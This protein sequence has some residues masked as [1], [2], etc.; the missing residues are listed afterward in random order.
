MTHFDTASVGAQGWLMQLG[1][2]SDNPVASIAGLKTLEILRRIGQYERLPDNGRRM[3]QRLKESLS[4]A[5]VAHQLAGHPAL[6]EVVFT[7]RP[8]R[9]YRD[10]VHADAARASRFNQALRHNGL[11]KSPGKTCPS[12]A[13]TEEDLE[14][15]E[16]AIDASVAVIA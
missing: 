6:F 4:A 15:T 5:G 10:V 7:D 12:L 13:L 16:Q 8:V 11:F 9:N 14:H 3:M 2:L 1:T